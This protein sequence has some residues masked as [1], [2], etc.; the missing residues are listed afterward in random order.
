MGNTASARPNNLLQFASLESTRATALSSQAALVDRAL[1]DFL[2]SCTEFQ[3]GIEADLPQQLE[4]LAQRADGLSLWVEQVGLDFLLADAGGNPALSGNQDL[5]PTWATA[6]FAAGSSVL[7]PTPVPLFGPWSRVPTGYSNAGSRLW[8]YI[9]GS[10]PDTIFSLHP[11]AGWGRAPW[12][13]PKPILRFDYGP[14]ATGTGKAFLPN[15]TAVSVPPDPNYFHWN[16]EG[17]MGKMK[18]PKPL[19]RSIDGYV[20]HNHQLMTNNPLPRGDVFGPIPGATAVK[21]LSRGLFVVGAAMDV[22]DIATSENKVR[23]GVKVASG[24]AGAWAGAEGGA[25]VGATIGTFF[26]PG[27]G[28]AVGGFI[29]GLV[30][31]ILGYTGGSAAGEWAYDTAT[32]H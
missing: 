5:F 13:L 28:T 29:G 19:W 4:R 1:A 14:I 25:A 16:I 20:T 30:G 2:S 12:Q 7:G 31:G 17:G 23:E 26:G 22:Y 8:L 9:G 3:T 27:P 6:P 32:K 11:H 15:G 24:W 10:G 18:K 21:G